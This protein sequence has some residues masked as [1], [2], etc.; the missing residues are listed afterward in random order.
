M[1]RLIVTDSNG[2]IIASGPHPDDVPDAPVRFGFEALEGQK[3]HEV[4]LPE[5]VTTVE[6]LQ[7]LHRTHVLNVKGKIAQLVR[8]S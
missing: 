8:T 6:H 3:V 2:Q 1:K 5:H 4:E 7:E